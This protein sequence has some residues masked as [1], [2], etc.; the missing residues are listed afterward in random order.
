MEL[1]SA[2]EEFRLTFYPET[3]AREGTTMGK[4]RRGALWSQSQSSPSCCWEIVKPEG[5][6]TSCSGDAEE[7]RKSFRRV[8]HSSFPTKERALTQLQR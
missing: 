3:I 6:H 7:E 8:G 4:C 5:L 1:H 2:P